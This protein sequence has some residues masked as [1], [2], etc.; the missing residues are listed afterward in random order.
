[1]SRLPFLS[2]VSLSGLILLSSGCQK[3]IPLASFSLPREQQVRIEA[4]F[5]PTNLPK[6]VLRIDHTFSIYDSLAPE[7]AHIQGASAWLL[8][9]DDTLATFEWVDSA[10][11]YPFTPILPT[12]SGP[13][14]LGPVQ[15][16][17]YGAYKLV[18][19]NFHL[20]PDT[21]YILVIRH[22]DWEVSTE[23]HIHPGIVVNE[24]PDS[25]A[26]CDCPGN[27][28]I[29][30]Y[31]LPLDGARLTWKP[32]SDVNI[33]T[34][35][36][37]LDTAGLNQII[38]LIRPWLDQLDSIFIDSLQQIPVDSLQSIADN[39]QLPMSGYGLK[40]LLAL[41]PDSFL[42]FLDS[43][44][45][46][47]LV[48]SFG[49]P[50]FNLAELFIS[51]HFDKYPDWLFFAFRWKLIIGVPDERFY[52]HYYLA[53]FPVN[54]QARNFWPPPFLGAAGALTEK[55]FSIRLHP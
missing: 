1:M 43:L 41:G 13:P 21:T 4:D 16:F 5:F 20:E 19:T 51:Q 46:A 2:I 37:E 49:V 26:N 31:D 25:V 22:H 27:Y 29:S 18:H 9:G 7:N 38:Q 48:F 24:E 32:F 50:E 6:S 39:L 52:R 33:Y 54:H 10:V 17:T 55:Y 11:T 34:A 28:S 35:Y 42:T 12:Q 14:V 47:P 40:S 53:D 8:M 45:L 23:L 44:H 15:F 36:F 30:Y 3:E